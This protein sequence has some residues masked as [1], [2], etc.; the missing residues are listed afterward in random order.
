V[1][2]TQGQ[3]APPYRYNGGG[4]LFI[5]T[6]RHLG[7]SNMSKMLNDYMDKLEKASNLQVHPVITGDESEEVKSWHIDYFTVT[8]WGENVKELFDLI[9]MNK[10]PKSKDQG[11]GGRF[12]RETYKTSL[13]VTIRNNPLDGSESRTTI[14][15]PGKACQ[16]LGFYGL[17]TFYEQLIQIYDKVRINRLDVAF[18]G[19]EFQ[20]EDVF[21]AVEN[22][23]LRSYLKRS[24]VKKYSAPFEQNDDGTIGNQGVVLGNRTST[25]FMRVYNKHGYTRLEVEYKKEKATQVGFDLLTSLT[26]EEALTKAMGHLRDY[27]DFLTDW[28]LEFV[29]EFDRLYKK[30]NETITEIEITKMKEWLE[31]QVSSAIHVLVEL[32]GIEYIE[33]LYKLGKMKYKNSRYSGL[34]EFERERNKNDIGR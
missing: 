34:I 29:G 12:Y 31:K 14:E 21:E 16:V 9:M 30:L 11:H 7:G 1:T 2:R 3:R 6:N 5:F 10:F 17:K 28:W 26:V 23:N 4:N 15:L 32:E 25:R 13:G 33:K 20:P 19:L 22:E 27:T 24:T 8:V 18:N